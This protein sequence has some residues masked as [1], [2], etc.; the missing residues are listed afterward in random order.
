MAKIK[1]T[2]TKSPIGA[3]PSQR[4]TVKALGLRKMHKS[5]E[6]EDTPSARG[7]IHKVSH[8]VTVE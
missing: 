6:L 1:V 7:A 4:K 8:L 5:V 3:T 2:L